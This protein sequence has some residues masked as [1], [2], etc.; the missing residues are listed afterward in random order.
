M[1][2]SK[3]IRKYI[4]LLEYRNSVM[5]NITTDDLYSAI[6]NYASGSDRHGNIG[7]K[8]VV[9]CYSDTEFERFKDFLKK[10]NIEFCELDPIPEEKATSP[11]PVFSKNKDFGI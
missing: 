5:L 3:D 6:I 4:N 10:E 8:P 1:N 2:L 9:S 7:S 11:V